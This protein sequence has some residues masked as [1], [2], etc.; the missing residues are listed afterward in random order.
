[1]KLKEVTP[2]LT[3][4]YVLN[5]HQNKKYLATYFSYFEPDTHIIENHQDDTVIYIKIQDE[6]LIAIG[7]NVENH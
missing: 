7:I 2:L 3:N 1:M 5:V 6:D 4:H